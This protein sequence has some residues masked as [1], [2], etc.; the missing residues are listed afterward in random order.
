V[1]LLAA[2]SVPATAATLLLLANV[3]LTGRVGNEI[4]SVT[5]GVML[6]LTALSLLFGSED[7]KSHGIWRV[8]V[9][10]RWDE[11]AGLRR[12]AVGSQVIDVL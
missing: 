8:I 10:T 9:V 11:K 1:G 6:F 5:L 4:I 2:G 3:D 7:Y 12:D